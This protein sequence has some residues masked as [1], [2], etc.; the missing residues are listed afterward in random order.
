[1]KRTSRKMFDY[2]TTEDS[3]SILDKFKRIA[4]QKFVTEDERL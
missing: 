2:F 3:F 4:M 1:V